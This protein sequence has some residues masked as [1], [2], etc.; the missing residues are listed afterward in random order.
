MI[1]SPSFAET[2]PLQPFHW[3]HR[4]ILVSTDSDKAGETIADLKGAQAAIEER[5]IIWF[6]FSGQSLAT[7]NRGPLPENFRTEVV[8]RY[9]GINDDTPV[10]LIGKDGGVKEKASD[11]NL[12]GLFAR[13]D[14]M[15]MRRAE[16]R[17]D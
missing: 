7:N 17:R 8:Q 12:Q 10:R 15:P 6:V 9:F 16:M 2:D 3:K 13:I 11:L 4:I 14:A 5:H 1:A